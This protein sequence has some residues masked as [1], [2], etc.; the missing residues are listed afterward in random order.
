LQLRKN[1]LE[2]V[3]IKSIY[4]GGGTPS[5]LSLDEL[6]VILDAVYE[7]YTISKT[8][9][10]TLEANPDDLS[11]T[12]IRELAT[13]RVNRLSIGIQSFFDT[14]LHLM[15]RAH[16]GDEARNCLKIA[17]QYFDNITIDLMYG[18]PEMTLQE[19]K[20]NLEIAFS[21]DVNHISS[22]VLT[23]EPKTAL[24]KF[25]REGTYP[26]ISDSD[27]LA[28]FTMLVEETEKQGYI[29]YEI[30]SFGKPNYFSKHNSSYWKGAIYIGIGP[31][32]HSFNK[33]SRSWNV[34]NNPLYVKNIQADTLPL[35]TEILSLDDQY[36]EY[37]MIGMRTIWG[38]SLK[39]IQEEFGE[40]YK[41]HTL[42][43]AE[44]YFQEKSIEKDADIIRTTQKGKFLVDG[45]VAVFFKV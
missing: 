37:V 8:P 22:Y 7:N 32:A 29:Q 20:E 40:S 43:S 9:E 13:S 44:H 28:H 26:K 19:W 24:E 21:F 41:T 25:I 10:I 42:T 6:N 36:N 14:H 31:G 2:T 30:S 35:T 4:F 15:N 12:K 23:V 45:I 38:I 33:T 34:S 39:Y 1:E 3:T 11:E 27:S 17:T 5:L 18:I 16:K